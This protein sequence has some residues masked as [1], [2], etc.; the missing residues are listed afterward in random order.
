MLRLP[1]FFK[2]SAK[3]ILGVE[4]D[5]IVTTAPLGTNR[6]GNPVQ[7]AEHQFAQ[8][9]YSLAELTLS[10]ADHPFAVSTGKY[11]MVK[12]ALHSNADRATRILIKNAAGVTVV[13]GVQDTEI[14]LG[15][16][17]QLDINLR[18]DAPDTVTVTDLSFVAAD[19]VKSDLIY[20][21]YDL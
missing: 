3:T 21:E 7:Y 19:T 5:E 9:A 1:S 20:E 12:H 13:S 14:P 8:K 17:G 15:L 6:K 2:K 4:E 18:F 16:M 11:W 10:L